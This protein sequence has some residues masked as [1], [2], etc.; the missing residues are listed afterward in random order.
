MWRQRPRGDRIAEPLVGQLVGDQP[1]GAAL[2]VAV[3]GAEDRNTLRLKG[4]L[5]VVIGDHHRVAGRQRIR[6]EQLDEQLHHL[7]LTAEVVLEVASQVVRQHRVYL[8]A[9]LGHPAPVVHA[10]LQRD[11][12][13]RR[14]LGLLVGPGGHARAGAARQ[15]LAVGQ[16]VIRALGADLDAEAGLGAGMVVAGK[17]RRGA[18]GLARDEHPVGQLL[19][20]DFAPIGVDRSGGAAV[21]HGDRHRRPCGQRLLQCDVQLA[22][23]RPELGWASAVHRHLRHRQGVRQ[24]QRE[25]AQRRQRHGGDR[26][27]PGQPVDRHL[28]FEVEFVA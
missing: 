11:Q 8:D 7:R 14:R 15:Q 1:F 9:V 4:Y 19:E 21:A 2:A 17:P 6:P 3:V 5:Q 12:I 22:V 28:V 24:V 26:G 13:R 23:R 10:D 25:C 18:V 16:R 27:G 20:T